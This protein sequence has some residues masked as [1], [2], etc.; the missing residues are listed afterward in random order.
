MFDEKLIIICS[1]AIYLY[2]CHFKGLDFILIFCAINILNLHRHAPCAAPKTTY[3]FLLCAQAQRLKQTRYQSC[4]NWIIKCNNTGYSC[5]AKHIITYMHNIC[6]SCT[7]NIITSA[8]KIYK[9]KYGSANR[10]TS[11]HKIYTIYLQQNRFKDLAYTY[12]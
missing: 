6:E 2:Y 3:L 1:L 7:N 11:V 8:H 4:A 12:L 9:K 5:C 10:I